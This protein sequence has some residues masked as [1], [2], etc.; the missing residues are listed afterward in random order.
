QGIADCMFAED[1]EIV[2]ID[3]KTDRVNSESVL[4]AR[5]DLQIKLYAA[6]LERIFGMRVKEAYLYSFC[7]NRAVRAL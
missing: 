1:G 4:T 3:Y 6:A 7:L 2:L 5:Y